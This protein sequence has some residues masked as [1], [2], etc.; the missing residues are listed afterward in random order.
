MPA[1]AGRTP[2]LKNMKDNVLFIS[3]NWASSSI[4]WAR[5]CNTNM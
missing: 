2:S 3:N 1:Y 4:I 5:S